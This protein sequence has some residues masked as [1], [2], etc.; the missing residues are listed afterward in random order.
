MVKYVATEKTQALQT[1]SAVTCN[2]W[3]RGTAHR[4]QM[5]RGTPHRRR[6][7]GRNRT[8]V[9]SAGRKCTQSADTQRKQTGDPGYG[10]SGPE[11]DGKSLLENWGF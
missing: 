3:G 5:G 4:Q 6:V 9:A 7:G 1:E 2:K 10:H 8:Q 11:K